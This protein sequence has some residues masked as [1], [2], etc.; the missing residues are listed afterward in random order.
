MV[1][2]SWL[3]LEFSLCVGLRE[4]FLSLREAVDQ[5]VYSQD[6]TKL[7]MAFNLDDGAEDSLHGCVSTFF[8]YQNDL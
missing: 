5:A 3:Y 4:S 7:F 8:L 1:A 2:G 6:F